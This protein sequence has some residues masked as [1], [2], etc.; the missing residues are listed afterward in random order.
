MQA[1]A[2]DRVGGQVASM[3]ASYHTVCVTADPFEPT[4]DEGMFEE[5]LECFERHWPWRDD[6][7]SLVAKLRWFE[8][9]V[10]LGGT[11]E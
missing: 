4:L 10:H 1:L 5:L 7:E 8:D 11:G 9:D 2:A 3:G 6:R